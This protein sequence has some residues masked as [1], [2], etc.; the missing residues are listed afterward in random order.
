MEKK[1]QYC[2]QQFELKRSDSVFCSHSC[3]QMAYMERKR[4]KDSGMLKNLTNI[5][6]NPLENVATYTPIEGLE[7]KLDFSKINPKLYESLKP[8]KE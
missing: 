6:F 2:Q 5:Q 7:L 8:N 1:C 3:R 4:V